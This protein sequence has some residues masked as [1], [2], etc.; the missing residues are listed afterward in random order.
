MVVNYVRQA[1]SRALRGSV[2]NLCQWST[3]NNVPLFKSFLQTEG[4]I[5]GLPITVLISI[6]KDLPGSPM[7]QSLVGVELLRP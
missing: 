4:A 1:I 5:N 7:R 2:L 6:P 3:R